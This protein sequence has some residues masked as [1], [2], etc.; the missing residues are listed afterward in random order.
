MSDAEIKIIEGLLKPHYHCF[1][2]GSG[3]ST[4]YFP[5]FV[6]FWTSFEH[7]PLYYEG[8]R[9]RLP[10]NAYVHWILPE[11]YTFLP[12]TVDF[13]LIDGIRRRDC[14]HEAMKNIKDD[15][16][17]LLHDALRLEYADWVNDFPNEILIPGEISDPNKDGYYLHRG[18]RLYKKSAI[19]RNIKQ[20]I[21][22]DMRI[23][24]EKL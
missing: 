1:E 4:I 12:F 18:L 16:I 8:V 24:E 20:K 2:W 23:T 21:G 5:K 13:I 7:D 17:I 6:D 3:G 15:G 14:L 22:E 10:K 11:V 9:K 19:Y